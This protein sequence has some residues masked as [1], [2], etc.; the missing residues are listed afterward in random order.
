MT[1]SPPSYPLRVLLAVAAASVSAVGAFYLQA[2]HTHPS[3]FELVWN[4]ARVWLG[5]ESPYAAIG[6]GLSIEWQFPQLYPFPAVVFAIPF[7]FLSAQLA[8][9]CFVA[10]SAGAMAW[11]I[12]SERL[13]DPRWWVFA[14]FAYVE[15]VHVAQWSPLMIAAALMP[16]LSFVLACKPTI[17]AAFFVAFPRWRTALIGAAFA[18]A[19]IVI[20]PKWIP[21]WLN[22]L[23]HTSHMNAPVAHL[24]V[25]GPLLLLALLRWRRPEA[26]LLAALACI[27]QTTLLYETLP[28]F[29][30]VR[31]WYE[32][33]ALAV[34]TFATT[35]LPSLDRTHYDAWI[36][37]SGERL[38]LL[39]YLPCLLMVLSRRN[40]GDFAVANW[41][42]DWWRQLTAK[43]EARP[44]AVKRGT[45]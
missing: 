17:G 4:A 28:L 30:V 13:D 39:L 36:W 9:I 8:N 29:L 21:E 1:A 3:D 26:R 15:A 31:R 2:L 44:E 27:P 12:T 34:L 22:T 32:G 45:A 6:P 10:I 37:A 33:V 42:R 40:V 25:G 7:S 41:I 11:A 23:S 18:L 20:Y 14:S 16:S 43:T 19:T 35:L 24:R 5:G 38:T